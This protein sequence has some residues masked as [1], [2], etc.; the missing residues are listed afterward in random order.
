MASIIDGHPERTK[1]IDAIIAGKSLREIGAKF[2]IPPMT[3]HR[4]AKNVV[5]PVLKWTRTLESIED[6]SRTVELPKK[7]TSS[8]SAQNLPQG[9]AGQ[10]ARAAA[11]VAPVLERLRRRNERREEWLD[12]A[13]QN[14]DFRALSSFDSNG[15]REIE[16]ECKLTGL[17]SDNNT[18]TSTTINLVCQQATV[19]LGAGA[20]DDEGA[21]DITA[22]PAE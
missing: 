5:K 4:F 14:E 3:V 11:S 20:A 7:S 19:Q 22:Q 6:N 15:L 1:I 9:E 8:T 12:A 2:G 17:L 16:L 10:L 13:E 21:I 18:Q